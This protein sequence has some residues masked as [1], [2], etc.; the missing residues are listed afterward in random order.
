MKTSTL[1][2]LT[3]L[4][5]FSASDALPFKASAKK[6]RAFVPHT[7]SIIA[8]PRGGAIKPDIAAAAVKTVGIVYLLQGAYCTLAPNANA[9][10]Y[11]IE[12]MKP[13]NTKIFRRLGLSDLNL[14]VSIFCLVIKD[15]G[16]KTAVAINT[17]VWVAASLYSLWNKESETI[18]PSRAGDLSILT[19]NAV[20]AYAALNGMDWFMTSFKAL[21]VYLVASSI[22]CLF[23]PKFAVKLWDI[24]GGDEM[25]R[26]CMVVLGCKISILS[27]LCTL[28]AWDVSPITA[29]GYTFAA[30]AA[31]FTKGYFFSADVDVFKSDKEML[32][33]WPISSAVMARTLL[34]PHTFSSP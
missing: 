25:T 10:A 11:G 14:G 29:L 34:S 22:P 16:L 7:K 12:E 8:I 9:Y 31:I 18:G 28:L 2:I 6:A 17:L 26:G 4:G 1:T 5:A 19:V 13:C 15:C 21:S 24:K 23:F 3:L 33:F 32:A 20:T 27:V 30:A